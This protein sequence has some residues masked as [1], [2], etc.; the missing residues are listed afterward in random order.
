MRILKKS[1]VWIITFLYLIMVFGFVDNRYENLLCNGIKVTIQDSL[2]NRFI[3]G[4]DIVRS[5]NQEGIQYLGI[6][7]NSLDLGRMENAVKSNQLVKDC[8]AYTGINGTL[9]ID[10]K[11]RE[12]VVRIIES[13]G[14]SYYLDHEGNVLNL[15]LRYT[16]HILVVNGNIHT[17]LKVGRPSNIFRLYNTNANQLLKDILE[18][19]LYI[20]SSK[21]WNAQIVQVYVN[22]SGDFELVPRIGPHVIIFGKLTDYKEKFDKLEIFYKEGLNN[23]GWNQYVKIN[24]KYKNQIV[25]SKI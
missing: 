7:L 11:Q 24:L 19:S 15:S 9:H 10:V 14:R 2:N 8:K 22:N 4:A 1:A 3:L 18:L 17:Q 20:E 16:P 13:D 23:I 25:C 6:K 12:P 21:L 5:I